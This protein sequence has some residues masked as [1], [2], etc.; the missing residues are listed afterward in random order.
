MVDSIARTSSVL[1]NAEGGLSD[2]SEAIQRQRIAGLGFLQIAI[3]VLAVVTAL[4]H[5]DR[6]ITTSAMMSHAGAPP[7]G[8]HRGPGAGG[9]GILAMI[10]IPL[11]ILF[12]LNFLAYIVL[13]VLLYLPALH[14]IQNVLRWLLVIMAAVTIIMWYLITGGM[15][16]IL[17][18][19]DKPVEL[20]LIIL[21]L[22]DWRQSVQASKG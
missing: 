3:I 17:S 12:Y 5:L 9:P 19:I 7:P 18:I 21:L 11:P 20:A 16:N 2:M 10:P 8:A 15:W 22:I 1:I 13:S 14:P 6:G 4:V